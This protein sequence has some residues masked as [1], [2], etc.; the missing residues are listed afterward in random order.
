MLVSQ[1]RGLGSG[2]Q[3]S[4]VKHYCLKFIFFNGN[5]GTS[6]RESNESSVD[7]DRRSYLTL[8]L[9]IPYSCQVASASMVQ[10][11]PFSPLVH[12]LGVTLDPTLTFRQHI[13][14]ICKTAYFELRR[15]S[16]TRHYLSA[17]ATKTLVCSLVLSRLDHY[18]SLL[19]GSPKYHLR[20]F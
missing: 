14:N 3:I 16:S 17:D 4:V 5:P 11:I 13:W 8:F 7:S 19:A 18:N 10:I 9:V 12:T 6:S 2:I 15:I 1:Q 20:K